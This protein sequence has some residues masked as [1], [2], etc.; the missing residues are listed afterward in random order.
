MRVT[1]KVKRPVLIIFHDAQNISETM[2]TE[3]DIVLYLKP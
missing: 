3:I 2:L 1:A